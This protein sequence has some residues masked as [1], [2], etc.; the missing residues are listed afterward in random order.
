M[1]LIAKM[2]PS[3]CLAVLLGGLSM[4]VC[5]Q[6]SA[7][8]SLGAAGEGAPIERLI[9]AVS[10]RTGKKFLLDP[11]VR[12][13]V[14]L[15]GQDF[16]K[17]DYDELL[18]ILDLYGFVAVENSGYV[19]VMPDA[20][21]RQVATRVVTGSERLPDAEVV[22][23]VIRVK[24][25]PAAYLVPIL[26]PLLPQYAHL[27]AL[28]CKNVLIVVDRFSNIRRIEQLIQTFDTGEPV[29]TEKCEFIPPPRELA[30]PAAMP[31]PAKPKE[32][33]A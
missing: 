23:T 15:V 6:T 33:G 26:R 14:V 13:N 27:A 24:S 8:S 21:A 10:Q 3:V 7:T 22:S 17:V 9:E 31:E 28:P 16:S 32:P 11:R 19:R 1:R 18:A 4:P 12:A 29:A 2:P 5:A 25:V 30:R 20:N